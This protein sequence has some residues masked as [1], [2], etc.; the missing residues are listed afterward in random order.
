VTPLPE[1]STV[2]VAWRSRADVARLA[3]SFPA[4]P[5]HEL[6]VVD[7]FGDLDG[8]DLGA[9]PAPRRLLQP[10]RNLGFAAGCNL[11]ARAA[12]GDHLLFLNPDTLPVDAAFDRLLA[13]FTR[14]PQADGLV[15][16]LEG[17]TGEG[18][19]RWQLRPL[20]GPWAL[21]AHAFFWNPSRGPAA[22]PPA[23][24]PVAQPAAAALALRR[25]TFE[26][27]GG[28]DERFHPA[29]FE[30]VDLARRLAAHGARVVYEPAACF[31]HR[32]GA[33]LAG[34]GYGGFLAA[35]DRNLALYL[36][37]HHGAAW[38]AAFRALVPLGALVRLALLPLR[39]PRRAAS[40]RQ[41]ARDLLGA[42]RQA[43][44]GWP[45]VSAEGAS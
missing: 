44:R 28:F 14:W 38:A 45:A 8:A 33:A 2:V 32:G 22:P 21:L 12:T 13:G 31:R 42:A 37:L 9:G 29:W 25:A 4:S 23:G 39:R 35:Y 6:V 43:L 40:R 36:R 41:A 10:G 19:H 24:T 16:R 26:R 3:A 1:L 30:D 27:V 7:N 5:R 11:G 17:E 15:P 18:Q 34:T 20:P